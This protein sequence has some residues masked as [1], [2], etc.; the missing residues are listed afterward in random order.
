MGVGRDRER[1]WG[2]R[3]EER[4]LFHE[5]ESR[6]QNANATSERRKMSFFNGV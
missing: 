5:R 1:G 6:I 3:E 2:A 4:I